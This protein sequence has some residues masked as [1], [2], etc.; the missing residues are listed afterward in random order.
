MPQ[1]LCADAEGPNDQPYTLNQ[2]QYSK[3]EGDCECCRNRRTQQQDADEEIKNPEDEVPE[4]ASREPADN[5]EDAD[6]DAEY[7]EINHEGCGQNRR[8]KQRMVQNDEAGGDAEQADEQRPIP[9][10]GAINK[11]ARQLEDADE[12]PIPPEKKGDGDNGPAGC[13]EKQDADKNRSDALKQIDPPA[14]CR[15][16]LRRNGC[17]H[18]CSS[19]SHVLREPRT[20]LSVHS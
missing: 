17:H 7:T 9:R 1:T 19:P 8:R 2:K 4:P 11:Y 10:D 15:Y 16:R 6:D 3:H 20:S 5:G 18:G 14:S 12:K 13:G